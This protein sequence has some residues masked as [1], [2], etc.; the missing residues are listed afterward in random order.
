MRVRLP[1]IMQVQHSRGLTVRDR[2]GTG[3]EIA[4][5]GTRGEVVDVQAQ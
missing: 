3:I 1:E 5:V 4:L 2:A